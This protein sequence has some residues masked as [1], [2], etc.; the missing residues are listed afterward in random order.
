MFPFVLSSSSF[1]FFQLQ[2]M[3]TIQVKIPQLQNVF[4]NE[5]CKTAF[6]IAVC[7]S[8]DHYFCENSS[9]SNL[10]VF[11]FSTSSK[12]ILFLISNFKNQPKIFLA[13]KCC[14]DVHNWSL[15]FLPS[16]VSQWFFSLSL[17]KTWQNRCSVTNWA[18]QT[19]KF[20]S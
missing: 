3:K 4:I 15:L 2:G 6:E 11:I 1:R 18:S 8:K 17:S 12:Q 19:Q 13:G 14:I 16:F 20:S 7:V 10:L 5:M 9:P